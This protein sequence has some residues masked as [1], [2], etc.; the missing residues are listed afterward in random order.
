MHAQPIRFFKTATEA[1]AV[2]GSL[3]KPSK[4]PGAGYGLPALVSCNVGSKLAK[5][6]GTVCYDCYACKGRYMFPNVK[7]AQT[8]RL[9]SIERDDWVDA[10]V[11][12][13]ERQPSP[14]FRWHDSGDLISLDHLSKICEIAVRLPNHVFWLP[15]NEHQLIAEYRRNHPIPENLIIRLS[16]PKIDGPAVTTDLCTSGVYSKGQ[17]TGHQCPAP[18][19]GGQCRDCRA[20]W[21]KEIKH[22]SYKAH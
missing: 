12:L 8:K 6:P 1:Q 11:T 16:S 3:S 9:E 20:C 2:V 15:T 21:D 18:T 13:I 17:P 5:V 10:M 22:V 7:T 4:M 19:Q 14:Y